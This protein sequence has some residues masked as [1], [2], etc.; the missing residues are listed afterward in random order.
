MGKSNTLPPALSTSPLGK[1]SWS[2][3]N[4]ASASTEDTLLLIVRSVGSSCPS[5][6]VSEF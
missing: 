4:M 5:Y 2:I 6:R 3:H 1:A